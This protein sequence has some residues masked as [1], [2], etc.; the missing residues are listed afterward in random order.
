MRGS[1]RSLA[2]LTEGLELFPQKLI[3]VPVERGFDWE[4]HAGLRRARSEVE[5]E[6]G[7]EGRVLIR[8]S[9]TEPLLRLMVETRDAALA[10]RAAPHLAFALQSRFSGA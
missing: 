10:E 8:A 1:G 2:E 7:T 9:G 6:L 5:A 4:G 3:N